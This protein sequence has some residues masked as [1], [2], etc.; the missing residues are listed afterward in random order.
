[1]ELNMREDKTVLGEKSRA[2]GQNPEVLY[3]RGEHSASLRKVNKRGQSRSRER[4]RMLRQ[5]SFMV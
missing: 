1:M 5:S 4:S 2:Q 3:L